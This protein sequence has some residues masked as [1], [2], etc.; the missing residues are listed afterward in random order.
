[1]ISLTHFSFL[2]DFWLVSRPLGHLQSFLQSH[3]LSIL[4]LRSRSQD[5]VVDSQE[6]E[7]LDGSEPFV[8]YMS[9]MGETSAASVPDL[10]SQEIAD[11]QATI[12][13]IPTPMSG[14][15]P[16]GNSGASF[17]ILGSYVW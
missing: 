15:N 16:V 8:S 2:N 14:L 11:L 1:M 9:L 5:P 17:C 12:G 3:L 10:T 7:L 13:D 4:L 6:R